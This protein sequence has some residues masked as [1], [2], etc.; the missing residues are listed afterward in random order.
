MTRPF[1]RP[2]GNPLVSAD[3]IFGD[4][5]SVFWVWTNPKTKFSTPTKCEINPR[6]FNWEPGHAY[7]YQWCTSVLGHIGDPCAFCNQHEP[8]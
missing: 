6:S 1:K 5:T 8:V 2:T 4:A 3:K 7:V